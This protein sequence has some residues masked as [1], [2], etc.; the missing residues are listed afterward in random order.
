MRPQEKYAWGAPPIEKV[1]TEVI[2]PT[3]QYLADTLLGKTPPLQ[4][5]GRKTLQPEELLQ[6]AKL[7]VTSRPVY[8]GREIIFIRSALEE[9]NSFPHHHPLEH[10]PYDGKICTRCC[11]QT[12]FHRGSSLLRVHHLIADHDT[13]AIRDERL[14]QLGYTRRGT[15]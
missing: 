15:T 13:R 11:G 9:G 4:Q 14:T 3:R 8:W 5:R 7:S 2:A 1:S 10:E 12:A 6:Q